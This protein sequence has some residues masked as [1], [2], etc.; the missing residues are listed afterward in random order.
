MAIS[1]GK[2]FTANEQV[3]NAKL[4][5]LVDDATIDAG[6]VGSSQLASG[7]V[8]N[9]KVSDTAGIALSKIATTFGALVGGG[10][11]NVSEEVTVGSTLSLTSSELNI[12]TTGITSGY[13]ADGAVVADKL[14]STL[15]L[16]SKTLTL[17][18][19][20][21]S[22]SNLDQDFINDVSDA[23]I[24]AADYLV[25]GDFSAA[26]VLKRATVQSVV[27]AVLTTDPAYTE[28]G[29]SINGSGTVKTIAAATHG[30]GRAPYQAKAWLV[31]TDAGGDAGYSE[32]D[33]VSAESVHE[34][35]SNS[36]GLITFCY[37]AGGDV[38]I[39][40]NGNGDTVLIANKSSGTPGTLT[41]SKWSL[42]VNLW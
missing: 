27:D 37:E 22:A 40:E 25:F 24:A 34:N 16:S 18:S 35:G 30:L 31:C 29:I 26:G 23:S 39:V 4:H 17:P 9:A 36:S 7:A 14:Y 8:T 32:N 42:T 12:A 5:Q 19:G 10:A 6:A 1:K 28:S 38:V 15:D 3:T 11:S 21:V 33:I 41:K 13:L 20:A 2:T